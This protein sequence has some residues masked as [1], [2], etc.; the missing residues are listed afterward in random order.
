MVAVPARLPVTTPSA[1]TDT[2]FEF[3]EENFSVPVT[4][5]GSMAAVSASCSPRPM[6]V[7]AA[8][9]VTPVGASLY[10]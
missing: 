9:S 1:D 4:S 3:E 5:A 6:A 10:V 7:R 2:Y 8:V